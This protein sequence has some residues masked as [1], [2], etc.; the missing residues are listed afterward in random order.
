[1]TP[2]ESGA[3]IA[4]LTTFAMREALCGMDAS[5]VQEVVRLSTLTAVP[6]VPPEV[7]GIMNLR[8]RIV[9]VIDAGLKL[10]YASVT[11]TADSRILII[12][13][14]GEFLGMLV[15]RVNE[16]IES[17]GVKWEPL[18]ANTAHS[19]YAKGVTRVGGKVL[20]LVD[21]SQILS[22]GN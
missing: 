18:P 16:V 15:D 14:R 4:L 5:N 8:G 13:D 17:E 10:G 19:R 7:A 11:P 2:S 6:F 20:T 22:A 1:M 12:E 21:A 3:G 9:T